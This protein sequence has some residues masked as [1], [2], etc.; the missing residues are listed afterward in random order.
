MCAVNPSRISPTFYN[1]ALREVV[2]DISRK[3]NCLLEIVNFNVDVCQ[4]FFCSRN[5]FSPGGRFQ[6]QQYVCAGEL[7]ALQTMTNILNYL[8]IQKVDLAKVSR[9]SL[10]DVD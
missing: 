7:V 5:Y 6:G 9:S 2:D 4:F 3:I 8:K 10:R 1:S